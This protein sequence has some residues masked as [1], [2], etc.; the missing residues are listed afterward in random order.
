MFMDYLI[1]LID[2]GHQ[3]NYKQCKKCCGIIIT[4]IAF[5]KKIISTNCKCNK[6]KKSN[7]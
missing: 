1:F 3:T 6:N 5:C 4:T 7:N 2:M